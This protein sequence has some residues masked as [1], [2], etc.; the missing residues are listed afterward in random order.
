MNGATL[1][2]ALGQSPLFPPAAVQIIAAG[3]RS[4]E[5]P[6]LMLRL[7]ERLDREFDRATKAM[8]SLIEPSMIVVM[9]VLVGMIVSSLMIPLFKMSQ[10]VH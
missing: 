6:R 3:E 4:G 8:I 2:D 7:A 5:T 10:V 9:G 1:S